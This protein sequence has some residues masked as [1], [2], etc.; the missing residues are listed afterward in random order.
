M[1]YRLGVDLGASCTA[2]AVSV[3]G[4]RP[5]LLGLSTR[6]PEMPS[7]LYP[8]E[9][10]KFLVGEVAE[11]AGEA[12]PSRLISGFKRRLG[13][14]VPFAVAGQSFAPEALTAALLRYVA[15]Q[16]GARQGG[17]PT[18]LVLTHPTSWGSYRL[19]VFDRAVQQAGVGPARRCT[20]AEAGAAMY[21]SRN[22][23]DPG[24]KIAVYDLGGGTFDVTVLERTP[25]G[26]NILG[27]PG[28]AD[29]LGG[30]AFDESVYRLVMGGLGD[31]VRDLDQADPDI[32]SRLASIKRGCV[33]AKETLSTQTQ[34]AVPVDLPGFTTTVKIT[35]SEFVSLIRPALRD[36]TAAVR[37]VLTAA[38]T[39][40]ERADRDR[41]DRWQLADSCRRR[42]PAA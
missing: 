10:G 1:A 21:A 27:T 6:A 15:G 18:E 24:M 32:V 16:A 14:D 35:R 22:Q 13:E 34:A 3:D 26:F 42:G 40:A 33:I 5:E 19:E 7:V 23:L 28:E 2:A 8:G 37:R 30:T 12:D 25:A 38:N 41:A 17:A 39:E 29:G 36:T 9:D 20:E 4:A 11:R 31:R